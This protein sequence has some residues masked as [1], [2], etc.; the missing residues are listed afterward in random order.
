MTCAVCARNLPL[1]PILPRETP[2]PSL[3]CAPWGSSIPVHMWIF[4]IGTS[5]S[6]P[7][8][9]KWPPRWRAHFIQGILRDELV[10]KGWYGQV[11]W[12]RAQG[13]LLR[14]CWHSAVLVM[15]GPLL[16]V[17]TVAGSG[18]LGSSPQAGR[19]EGGGWQGL[20]P[21]MCVQECGCSAH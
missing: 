6:L 9:W 12:D 4:K 21:G 11:Q 19:S 13:V 18:R 8:I 14:G 17:A 2:P 15:S 7:P 10:G 3:L 16:S 20:K 1:R 5:Q